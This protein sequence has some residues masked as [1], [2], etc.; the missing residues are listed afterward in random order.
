MMNLGQATFVG[1]RP[2]LILPAN[3]G[4]LELHC[5]IVS[6]MIPLGTF[7]IMQKGYILILPVELLSH[8]PA[9]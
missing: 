4:N 5:A 7:S 8:N 3:Q 1:W 2:R 6:T 9:Y